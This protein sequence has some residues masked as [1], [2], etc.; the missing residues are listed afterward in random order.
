MA[1]NHGGYRKGSG[2]KPDLLK[3]NKKLL[4]WTTDATRRTPMEIVTVTQYD[5][6]TGQ[7]EL[8]TES[9][10]VYHLSTGKRTRNR[11]KS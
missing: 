10:L 9:G 4:L 2:R 5:V 6:A 1:N 3:L 11:V 7:A 8:T